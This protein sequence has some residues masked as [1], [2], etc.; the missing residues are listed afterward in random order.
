MQSLF[1]CVETGVVCFGVVTGSSECFTFITTPVQCL[2]ATGIFA[3]FC[4]QVDGFHDG[5]SE[6]VGMRYLLVKFINGKPVPGAVFFLDLYPVAVW[7]FQFYWWCGIFVRKAPTYLI[8]F[9]IKF[10]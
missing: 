7:G 2:D 4:D 3:F 10:N 9:A 8:A 5:V 1:R 6:L